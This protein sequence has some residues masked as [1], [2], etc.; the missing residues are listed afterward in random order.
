MLRDPRLKEG[1]QRNPLEKERRILQ[2][3][4]LRID[5]YDNQDFQKMQMAIESSLSIIDQLDVPRSNEKKVAGARRLANNVIT[6][7][8]RMMEAYE[9]GDER[10]RDQY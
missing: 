7:A 9:A 6:R 1:E 4:L 5:S 3:L 8:I 2:G 10:L